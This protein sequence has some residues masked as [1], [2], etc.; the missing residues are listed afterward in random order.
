[1][2]SRIQWR[3]VGADLAAKNALG[4]F[5]RMLLAVILSSYDALGTSV[6]L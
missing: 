5:W 4:V 3:S 6:S 1:M 2:G